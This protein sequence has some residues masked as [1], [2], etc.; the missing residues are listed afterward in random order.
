MYDKNLV[1]ENENTS[2]STSDINNHKTTNI[3]NIYNVE[4]KSSQQSRQQ[5]SSQSDVMRDVMRDAYSIDDLPRVTRLNDQ[6]VQSVDSALLS[7]EEHDLID[8]SLEE[9]RVAAAQRRSVGV[10]SHDVDVTRCWYFR[11]PLR[12]STFSFYSRIFV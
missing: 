5:Y 1:Q 2:S 6:E 11:L 8:S 12:T 9:E 4:K 3:H 10:T 7:A